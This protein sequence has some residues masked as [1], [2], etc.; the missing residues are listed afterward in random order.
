MRAC[1]KL[2]SLGPCSQASAGVAC[3]VRGYC[4]VETAREL[5]ELSLM[6]SM[7]GGPEG[8]HMLPATGAGLCICFLLL[9]LIA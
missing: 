3:F 8:S 4:L 1:P 5:T 2:T 9:L 7:V 6:Q